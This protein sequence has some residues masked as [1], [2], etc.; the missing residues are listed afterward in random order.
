MKIAVIITACL[1]IVLLLSEL[2]CG[3]WL[4]AG[5]QGDVGFHANLGVAAVVISIICFIL[6]FLVLRK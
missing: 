3:L 5:N 4:K 2:L 6:F 1:S